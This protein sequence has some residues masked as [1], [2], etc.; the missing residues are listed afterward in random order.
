M[1]AAGH[2]APAL[3][4]ELR[5]RARSRSTWEDVV[6][7]LEGFFSRHGIE[8]TQRVLADLASRDSSARA[9]AE[10]LGSP[11]LTYLVLFEAIRGSPGPVSLT[12]SSVDSGLQVRLELQ[13]GLKTSFVFFQCCSWLLASIPRARG[14][15]DARVLPG[16]LSERELDCVVIPP[17]G[18]ELMLDHPEANAPALASELFGSSDLSE[19]P[20]D[21]ELTA[22]VLQSRFGFTRAEARVVCKLAEGLSIKGIA[23]ALD[24]S[25]ETARTHAKRAMQ[26]TDTHRQAELVSLVLNAER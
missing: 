23:E 22:Q 12:W 10:L 24:V 18:P 14:M 3:L 11:R 15:V 17:L 25:F 9:V 6:V 20:S 21:P 2:D 4:K 26:K 7:L 8:A 1:E 16:Q 13:Q 19:A 5:L